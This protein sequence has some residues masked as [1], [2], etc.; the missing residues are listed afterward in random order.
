MTGQDRIDT[1]VPH[2]ARRYNYWLG[3]KDHFAADRASGDEI[4]AAFPTVRT[5]VLANR[6]FLR[7]AVRFLAQEAGVRQFLDI[8]TGLPV[9]DNTHEIAQRADPASR[10]LYVDNDPIVLT[11]ARALLTGTPEGKTAYLEADLRDP[12][13]ILA[14]PD[15]RSTLDLD[16]PVGLLLVAILHFIHTDAEA[17]PIVRTLLS[18]LPSGSYLVAT[19][20]TVDFA[21]EAGAAAYRAMFAAGRTDGYARTAAEF[22]AFFEGLDLVPPGIVAVSDWRDA[23]PDAAP[24]DVAMYAAVG[25]KP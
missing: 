20:A 23:Y 8:G 19:N 17:L 13:A 2:P 4:A 21:D 1:T 25:R 18:A 12:A 14:H 16:Q 7:G 22:G 24:A 9:P 15:L 3:G 11:H 5:A 6:A 10:V